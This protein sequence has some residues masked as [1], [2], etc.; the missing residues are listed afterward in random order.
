MLRTVGLLR[1]GADNLTPYALKL[2]AQHGERTTP[3][4]TRRRRSSGGSRRAFTDRFGNPDFPN[5]FN[6]HVHQVR[7][8][9]VWDTVKTDRLA[10][11]EGAVRAGPLAVHPPDHQRRASPG[12][13]WRSTS[14]AGPYPVYR[15]DPTAGGGVRRAGTSSS[16]SP[17]CTATSAASTRRPPAL[18]HRLR[19]DGRRGRRGRARGRR[20]RRSSGWP[21][22]RSV[23]PA[24][25]ERLDGHGPRQRRR[26]GACSAAGSH[27]RCCPATWCT[28]A[29]TPRSRRSSYRPRHARGLTRADSRLSRTASPRPT[30]PPH[31]GDR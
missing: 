25:P 21:A 27:A 12:T 28:R 19:V 11:P 23:T 9:G 15:F 17:A 4:P 5:P 18:R 13:R 8:L 1:P 3:T 22:S 24:P 10:Q 29:C 7:F 14:G 30:Y 26:S 2:Y 6:P 20:R 31:M 16:G